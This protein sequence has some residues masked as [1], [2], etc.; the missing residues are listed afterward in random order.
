MKNKRKKWKRLVDNRMRDYGDT[1]IDKRVIRVNKS[2][3]KNKKRGDIIDTIV[4]EEDHAKHP[5]KHE[6]TVRRDTKR[7]LKRMSRETKQRLYSKYK[8][9]VRR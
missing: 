4:H 9:K 8:K 5:R 3:K 1:D 2:K 6:K 7:K